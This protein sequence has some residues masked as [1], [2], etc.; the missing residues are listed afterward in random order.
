[1]Y[2]RTYLEVYLGAYSECTWECV[3]GLLGRISEAGW[4]C[5]IESNWE[6]IVKQAGSVQSSA[7]RSVLQSVL[8]SV[9]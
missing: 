3:E 1:V 9:Q 5:A 6:R 8:G 4:E 2:L 7:I